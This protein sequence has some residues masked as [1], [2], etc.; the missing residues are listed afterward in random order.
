MAHGNCESMRSRAF[1]KGRAAFDSDDEYR[2]ALRGELDG[3]HEDFG[4]EAN[5]DPDD[6]EESDAEDPWEEGGEEAVK[7]ELE[8]LEKRIGGTHFLEILEKFMKDC[9]G[10]DEPP[11]LPFPLIQDKEVLAVFRD[12]SG[13]LRLRY[14]AYGFE[15][16]R[17]ERTMGA[18]AWLEVVKTWKGLS[19]VEALNDWDDALLELAEGAELEK[20]DLEDE[21]KDKF[22]DDLPG[23]LADRKRGAAFLDLVT[24]EDDA[25]SEL[26]F[27]L[28]ESERLWLVRDRA[29]HEFR[30]E[31]PGEDGILAMW[32]EDEFLE[33]LR[34]VAWDD[35]DAGDFLLGGDDV[36]GAWEALD[37]AWYYEDEDGLVVDSVGKFLAEVEDAKKDPRVGVVQRDVAVCEEA[38]TGRVEMRMTWSRTFPADALLTFSRDGREEETF[39][40][41]PLAFLRWWKMERD[42]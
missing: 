24:K 37:D 16:D 3:V 12:G 30:L 8:D 4:Y 32:E 17:L 34:E 22:F 9:S 1:T 28:S 33:R 31:R 5:E 21:R 36:K 10:R 39:S 20:E 11:Y 38:D 26:R 25:A 13:G 14:G 2:R 41:V 35:P 42:W 27:K 40:G 7:A 23:I 6:G 18:E 15:A 19:A 29:K